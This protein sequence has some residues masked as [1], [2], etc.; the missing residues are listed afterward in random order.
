MI[1]FV[2]KGKSQLDLSKYFI[3]PGGP[4]VSAQNFMGVHWGVVEIF[5]SGWTDVLYTLMCDWV[6]NEP[7]SSDGQIYI[8]QYL[9]HSCGHFHPQRDTT[10]YWFSRADVSPSHKNRQLYNFTGSD[11]KRV[12]PGDTQYSKMRLVYTKYV[13]ASGQMMF[14]SDLQLRP[15]WL[16][17]VL[18]LSLWWM[19]R[20]GWPEAILNQLN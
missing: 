18:E 11:L 16:W 2:L 3:S 4:W 1:S 10:A 13:P 12:E 6:H 15:V 17:T 20:P 8:C 19:K 5:Q 14:L 9:R 7:S